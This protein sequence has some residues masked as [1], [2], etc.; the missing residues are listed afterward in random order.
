MVL[1][2]RRLPAPDSCTVSTPV[3]M[4]IVWRGR[5][6]S[7]THA[8]PE[9]PD[10]AS[11]LPHMCAAR[12]LALWLTDCPSPPAPVSALLSS[13]QGFHSRSSG[14]SHSSRSALQISVVHLTA[15][16]LTHHF[17]SRLENVSVSVLG[18]SKHQICLF[19]SIRYQPVSS[20]LAL[21]IS[22]L[23]YN[24]IDHGDGDGKNNAKNGL[25]SKYSTYLYTYDIQLQLYCNQPINY[26]YAY[27]FR[28]FLWCSFSNYVLIL[29]FTYSRR[30]S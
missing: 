23:L 30:L 10:K 22:C 9:V 1:P 16:L 15:S 13:A 19:E 8:M 26:L 21:Y 5:R 29:D 2:P 4:T 27:S 7:G 3:C 20:C 12:R 17:Y 18:R 28:E 14:G 11:H 6:S 24:I 25:I